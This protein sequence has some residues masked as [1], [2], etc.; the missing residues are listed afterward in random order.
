LYL[1][2]LRIPVIIVIA[3]L[4]LIL[5]TGGQW[6]YQ[7]FSVQRPFIEKVTN[8]PNVI[9]VE[10]DH[11]N[12]PSRLEVKLG[13]AGGTVETVT[14][15][16]KIASGTYN[17][18]VVLRLI[19]QR[20]DELSEILE[21]SQFYIYEALSNGN[22]SAMYSNIENLANQFQIDQ[23]NLSMNNQH[24]YLELFKGPNYLY[25]VIPRNQKALVIGGDEYHDFN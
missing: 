16:S 13:S 24:I 9:S 11:N 19:D 15:L 3:I 25:E 4:S 8:L 17:K 6:A 14:Q 10:L 22:Y 21:A 5:L 18:A 23:W 1:K 7:E 2:G 20:N 12:N